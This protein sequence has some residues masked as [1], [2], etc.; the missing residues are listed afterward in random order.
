VDQGAPFD[1]RWQATLWVN[2]TLGRTVA[3][4]NDATD[5]GDIINTNDRD[6]RAWAEGVVDRWIRDA[7]VYAGNEKEQQAVVRDAIRERNFTGEM[8]AQGNQKT[9]QGYFDQEA[10]DV[11]NFS[12]FVNLP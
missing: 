12:H 6:L 7:G 3:A 10:Q 2:Y 11:Q 4:E 9:W 1:Q 8:R 5:L